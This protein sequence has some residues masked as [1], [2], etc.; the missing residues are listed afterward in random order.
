M[1]HRDE[2]EDDLDM[3]DYRR[4]STRELL[5]LAE[6]GEEEAVAELERRRNI[7]RD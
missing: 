4:L 1:A 6:R 2:D 3:V 7:L 5:V